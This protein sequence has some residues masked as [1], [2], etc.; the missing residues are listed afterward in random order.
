M[1]DARDWY[2][3]IQDDDTQVW[4]RRRGQFVPMLDEEYIAWKE[5]GELPPFYATTV[6]AS[7]AELI[8]LLRRENVPPY[9]SVLSYRIVRRLEACGPEIAAAAISVLEAPENAIL[10]ARFYTLD[11]VGGIPADDPD[12]IALVQACGADPAVILAPD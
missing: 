1:M 9:H 6:I 11:A 12:A 10:K 7:E 8:A 4:S 5:R 3:L 2:Y